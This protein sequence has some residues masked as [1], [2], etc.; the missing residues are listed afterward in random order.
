MIIIEESLK[1]GWRELLLVSDSDGGRLAWKVLQ[2]VTCG[3][4]V[5]SGCFETMFNDVDKLAALAM[6]IQLSAEMLD[7]FHKR[8]QN[9]LKEVN[10]E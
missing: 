6:F 10:N 4:N 9:K 5:T 1:I 8:L 7:T 3:R 2:R